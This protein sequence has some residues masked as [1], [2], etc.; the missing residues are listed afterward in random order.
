M[1]VILCNC[2]DDNKQTD[3]TEQQYV[4]SIIKFNF[5]KDQVIVKSC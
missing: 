1:T 3:D 5:N 2:S 4:K